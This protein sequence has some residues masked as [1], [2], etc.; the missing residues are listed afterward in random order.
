MDLKWTTDVATTR[1]LVP[2]ELRK[3]GVKIAYTDSSGV[4]H[5][6]QYQ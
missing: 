5:V 4:Y 6:E 3:K 1:K 2:N